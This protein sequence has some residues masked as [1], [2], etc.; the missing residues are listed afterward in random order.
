MC[1]MLQLR[2]ITSTLMTCNSSSI[3]SPTIFASSSSPN[4]VMARRLPS[5]SGGGLLA[6]FWPSSSRPPSCSHPPCSPP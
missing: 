2:L 4:S 1:T 5:L 6:T 3:A